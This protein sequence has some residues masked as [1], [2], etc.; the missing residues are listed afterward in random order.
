MVEN[1][2]EKIPEYANI[3]CQVTNIQSKICQVEKKEK[4]I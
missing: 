4:E 2:D 1:F 3:W